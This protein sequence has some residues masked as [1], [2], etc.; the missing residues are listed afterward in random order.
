M[1]CFYTLNGWSKKHESLYSLFNNIV[2]KWSFL[3]KK[4]NE[5]MNER[6]N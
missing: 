4:K 2:S 3:K 6:M 5:W 1:R